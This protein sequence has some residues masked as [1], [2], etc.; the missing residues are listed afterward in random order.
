MPKVKGKRFPYT[1]KG[2]K[3]AKQYA[4]R[5]GGKMSSKSYAKKGKK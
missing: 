1:E 3:A 2:K 4:K 5:T